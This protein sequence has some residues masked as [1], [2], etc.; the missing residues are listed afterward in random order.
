[1]KM[2]LIYTPQN[3]EYLKTILDAVVTLLNS[4]TFKSALDIMVPLAVTMVGYQ[5]VMGKKLASLQRFILTSFFVTVCLLGLRAPVAIIDMQTANGAGTALNVD[6]V[7]IGIALP[8]AIISGMGYGITQLFSDVFVMPDDLDYNKT[9]MIFGARTWLAATNTRLSMSPDLATDMSSYIRQCVF[10]AKLLGSQSISPEELV[11]ST[12]L[13]ETYFDNP[14]PVYRVIFQDGSNLGCA[15]AASNLKTRLPSAAKRELDRLDQLMGGKNATASQSLERI[16]DEY[17]MIARSSAAI[18]TQ[19]ILINATRDAAADAFSFAGADAALM[20]YTNTTSMQK[21][22]VAEAN[23]FWLASYRLPYYMTVMW[24]LTICIFPLVALLSLLPVTQNV[25]FF[26]LQSQVYLWSWPPMFI[27]IHFFVSLASAHT[28]NI[29]GQQSG[30]YINEL[31]QNMG[32]VTFSN[33]DSLASMHSSFAYTAGALAA[34]VPFLAYYITKGLSS[35][36][37]NASQHFGGMVQ[38]MS[39][40]E[41][42]SASQ[43][44]ISMASYSGWNMNYD[45]TNAHK[46]DTNHSHAE[47]RKTIQMPNGSLLSQNADGS[48]V[49]NVSQ[50]M[51]TAPVSVNGSHRVI[52]ALHQSANESF[53]RAD[54]DRIAAD[55][56]LQSGLNEMKNFTEHDENAYRSGAGVSNTATASIGRDLRIMKDAIK[57]HNDHT[58]YASHVS[59]E[60]AISGH[61]NSKHSIPGKL[62]GLFTGASV[63]ASLTGRGSASR[64]R[65]FQEFANTSDGKAF[66]DAYHHMLATA[67]HNNLDT[68]DSHNLSGAEQIAA[69]FSTGESL[70]KQASAERSHGLQLQKAASHATEQASSIDANLSQPFHNWVFD[71]YGEKGEAVMLKTDASSIATQ[72]NWANEFLKSNVGQHAIGQEVKHVLART[73]GAIKHDYEKDATRIS[74]SANIKGRYVADG[75]VVDTKASKSGLTE[76][77]QEQLKS[78]KVIQENHRLKPIVDDGEKIEILVAKTIKNTEIK[79]KKEK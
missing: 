54:Q 74:A 15:A 64:N 70:L 13:M 71:R 9:G 35:V 37:S 36:L 32:G 23:S 57:H 50:A 10:A 30:S 24:M 76:M 49:G 34:S 17:K 38:S 3:A 39:V 43:G 65:S 41:A 29:F 67:K 6:N 14:S 59:I 33:I 56:H 63:D 31:G 73:D 42:Q 62:L 60:G 45:N 16:N 2:L 79:N 12:D 25:Y 26:Y 61:L 1:M 19:N 51:S 8:A 40:S 46:F 68:S 58:D 72:Q 77:N 20:N 55:A 27:I 75:H 44:N 22:H 78:A 11:N 28:I 4:S 53:G 47:G 21:M 69:N 52:D 7:P 18:L 48:R 5:Y 66:T